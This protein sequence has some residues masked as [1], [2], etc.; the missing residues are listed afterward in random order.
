MNKVIVNNMVHT[1]VML[2]EVMQYLAPRDGGVYL[3][4][5]FGAG[6]YTTAILNAANVKVHALD[7]DPEAIERAQPLVKH[8]GGRLEVHKSCFG[9]MG[10]IWFEPT[11]DGIV[12]DL[13]VSSPQLDQGERGFSFSKDAPLDMRMGLEGP[14]AADVVNTMAEEEL[15]N[16]IYKYGEERF[17]RRVARKIVETRALEP[18]THTVQLADLVRSVVPKG[19]MKIDQATRTFQ[20]LRIYVNDE[21]GELTRALDASLNLLKTGG[22]L[23]V[24]SFHSLEDGIVK[25]YIKDLSEA[26]GGSR[27]LPPVDQKPL[28]YKNLTRKIVLA[29]DEEVKNNPRARSAR[30]RAA[31]KLDNMGHGHHG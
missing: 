20:A 28:Q 17:S 9:D 27:H 31:E 14:T 3:D 26:K 5:T 24:V 11:F 21:L 13:G 4:C 18:I 29:S 10:S 15:A 12:F 19:S 25:A 16:I 2:P 1:P 7:R 30:L 6:G 23:V 8:F 22:R